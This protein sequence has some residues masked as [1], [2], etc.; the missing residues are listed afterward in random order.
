M[1]ITFQYFSNRSVIYV[2]IIVLFIVICYSV[3]RYKQEFHDDNTIRMQNTSEQ[4][5]ETDQQVFYRHFPSEKEYLSY[6]QNLV[7][8]NISF[9]L[10]L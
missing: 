3:F 6:I 4:T 10:C 1:N 9:V 5:I 7:L 8:K 2:T